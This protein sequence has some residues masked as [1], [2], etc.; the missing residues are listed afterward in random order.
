MRA[1]TD[2]ITGIEELLGAV[3][4]EENLYTGLLQDCFF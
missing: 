3:L 4:L 2:T 1:T